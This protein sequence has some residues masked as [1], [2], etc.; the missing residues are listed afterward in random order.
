MR[1]H[2]SAQNTI[3]IWS[4]PC[5]TGEEPYS[6]ALIIAECLKNEK[7]AIEVNIFATD[8]DK[9]AVGLAQKGEYKIDTLSDVKYGILNQYFEIE[10][11]VFKIDKSIKE[12]VNFSVYDL[13]DKRS[14]IPPES[15]FG[16]FDM[17]LCRNVLIYFN[18]DFQKKIFKKLYRSLNRGGYLI[19]GE[20]EVV[21]EKYRNEFRR[22]ERC[23]K[24]YQKR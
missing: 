8:I 20:A 12:M 5:A 17:V 2:R 14:F 13:L 18:T 21:I 6:V 19:L 15:I 7:A 1:K 4:C 10:K 3:N 23:C 9:K 22:I 16:N 24:I 11:D